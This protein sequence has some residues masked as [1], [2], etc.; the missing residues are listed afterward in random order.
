M[1]LLEDYFAAISYAG[2]TPANGK[3]NALSTF[4]SRARNSVKYIWFI[5]L[6]PRTSA[7]ITISGVF[8]A[9]HRILR[10]NK[11]LAAD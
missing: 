3:C 2:V 1:G 6:L 8:P 7:P 10:V 4:P 11:Y 9:R 5:T